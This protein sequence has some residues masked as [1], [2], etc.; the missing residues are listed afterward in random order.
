MAFTPP[1][2]CE[3]RAKAL[4]SA[5]AILLPPAKP[6]PKEVFEELMP[7][8]YLLRNSG[9]TW[10]HLTQL[11]RDCGLKLDV[12]T[13]RAYYSDLLAANEQAYQGKLAGNGN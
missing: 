1:N 11:L 6:R 4:L 7:Y 5:A 9:Y 2:Y 8:L 12:G 3:Q 10:V 13:V